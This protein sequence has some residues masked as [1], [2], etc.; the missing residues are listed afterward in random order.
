MK[1]KELSDGIVLLSSGSEGLLY[2]V[3]GVIYRYCMIIAIQDFI[4]S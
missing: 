1:T 4:S 2:A 3:T